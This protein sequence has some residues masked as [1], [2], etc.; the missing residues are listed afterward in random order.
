MYIL[1]VYYVCIYVV[2]LIHT[3]ITDVSMTQYER[4]DI[5]PLRRRPLTGRLRGL[6]HIGL[7]SAARCACTQSMYAFAAAH[8]AL[9]TAAGSEQ[10]PI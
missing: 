2:Q 7:L 10:H 1:C 9:D 3:V 8:L 6:A 5:L 4:V